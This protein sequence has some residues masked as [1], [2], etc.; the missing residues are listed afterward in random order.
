MP[1]KRAFSLSALLCGVLLPLLAGAGCNTI[2]NL[3]TGT[4]LD[5]PPDHPHDTTPTRERLMVVE[6][7]T[8]PQGNVAEI[9]FQRSSGKDGI[10]AYVA[11]TIRQS[12]PHQ[13]S[14]RSVASLTYSTEDGFS[15]PKVLSSTPL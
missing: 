4:H 3:G 1:T 14:T 13:P 11:E 6:V 2:R 9:H 12:W 8:D 10:D 15:A 7:T 5:A